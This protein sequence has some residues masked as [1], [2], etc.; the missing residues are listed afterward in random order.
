MENYGRQ[1]PVCTSTKMDVEH[2]HKQE[3]TYV[4]AVLESN[5]HLALKF[6]H[7]KQTI[8]E[9]FKHRTTVHHLVADLQVKAV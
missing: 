4:H 2:L 3:P 5:T 9:H 1:E 7:A 8:S 6:L